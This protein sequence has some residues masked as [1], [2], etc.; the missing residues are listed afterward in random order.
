MNKSTEYKSRREYPA[1]F[2]SQPTAKDAASISI[3]RTQRG[4]AD[5]LRRQQADC[6][7]TGRREVNHKNRYRGHPEQL[8]NRRR[9]A[10][11]EDSP[12]N[13]NA[14]FLPNPAY[15]ST[16]PEL[17]STDPTT[18]LQEISW[19][20]KTAEYILNLP[21]DQ[22]DWQEGATATRGESVA[23]LL[24]ALAHNLQPDSPAPTIGPRWDGGVE[25]EWHQ[26]GVD[27]ELSVAPN[28]EATWYF[29]DMKTGEEKEE[30]NGQ[31]VWLLPTT[32]FGDYILRLSTATD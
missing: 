22:D 8:N 10:F 32:K 14:P 27:L 17:A 19:I 13:A 29:A 12:A 7:S 26:N 6:R 16:D 5:R 30:E 23:Y 9:K 20:E 15:Y 2:A 1:T 3:N 11:N 18:G 24:I 31:Q 28:G 4:Q 25:A 21:W